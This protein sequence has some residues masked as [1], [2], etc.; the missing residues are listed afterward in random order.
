MNILRPQVTY[1]VAIHENSLIL[2][3]GDTNN[4]S[5]EDKANSLGYRLPENGDLEFKDNQLHILHNYKGILSKQ[6]PEE[7][8]DSYLDVNDIEFVFYRGNPYLYHTRHELL[9]IRVPDELFEI[10]DPFED[11]KYATT[12]VDEKVY[13]ISLSYYGRAIKGTMM[14]LLDQVEFIYQE[15]EDKSKIISK[16]YFKRGD[17]TYHLHE[18]SLTIHE[19]DIILISNKY[20]ENVVAVLAKVAKTDVCLTRVAKTEV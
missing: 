7:L 13:L 20:Q 9:L 14:K 8:L 5:P 4:L 16:S 19:E 6:V 2:S 10:L 17:K 3:P 12:I 11:N 15:D 18:C 1:S